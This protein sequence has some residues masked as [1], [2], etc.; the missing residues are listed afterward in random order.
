MQSIQTIET[1][2]LFIND[3]DLI[4]V[5]E[6]IAPCA[7]KS[8][9]GSILE[10]VNFQVRAGL[11]HVC[12]TDGSRLAHGSI[13]FSGIGA[14]GLNVNIPYTAFTP[15]AKLSKAEKQAGIY[16]MIDPDGNNKFSFSIQTHK[17]VTRYDKAL[18]S[19]ACVGG[20][21]P[22]YPEL[23]PKNF[24]Q[25]IAILNVKSAM[26]FGSHTG[27]ETLIGHARNIEKACYKPET[28][29]DSA[30][31][32]IIEL[33][34]DRRDNNVLGANCDI[35]MQ[36]E[37][38]SYKASMVLNDLETPLDRIYLAF[39]S[40][41]LIDALDHNTGV[42][43]NYNDELKPVVFTY[44]GSAVRHLLMPVKMAKRHRV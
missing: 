13:P 43:L 10:C 21:Y 8:G 24:K 38:F 4:D 32:G 3:K 36:H 19:G 20:E 37:Y 31:H 18:S 1:K 42:T 30:K 7:E 12:A 33:T 9:M 16:I 35:A 25:S 6:K 40:K 44:E 34:I 2:T 29:K 22:R 39:C 26:R 15:V 28:K 5:L 27:L 14:D 17:D 41:Y 23:F 11:L